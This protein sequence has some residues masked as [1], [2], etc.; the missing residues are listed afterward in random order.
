MDEPG[1]RFFRTIAQCRQSIDD[2][3]LKV[4]V[5]GRFS[6]GKSA[7]LNALLERELLA[8]DQGPETAVP[9][10]LV[11]DDNEYVELI[12]GPQGDARC[13]IAEIG[14]RDASSY[15][16]LR[17]HIR[18]DFLRKNK[19]YILV[20]MPGLDS[21]IAEHNKAI[22][23]YIGRGNAYILVVDCE[24]GEIKSSSIDF[25]REIKQYEHNLAIVVSKADK[26]PAGQVAEIVEQV[27][28]TAAA[29]FEKDIVAV[30]A[31]KFDNVV[32]QMEQVLSSF[33]IND[34]RAQVFAP[35][36]AELAHLELA[37]VK[38]FAQSRHFDDRELTE[39]ISMHQK[40]RER[41]VSL[42]EKERNKLA[43][44]IRQQVKPGIIADVQNVLYANSA[45]LASSLAAGGNAFTRTVNDLLRPVLIASTNRYTEASYQEFVRQINF[46]QVLDNDKL[47]AEIAAKYKAIMSSL[48]KM[49]AATDNAK[50]IY[51]S[52]TSILAI[53]TTVVAPWLEL[54]IVFLPDILKLF[55]GLVEK[56][57]ME[58]LRR[59]VET[60]IIPQIAAKLS[61]EMDESLRE[62]EANLIEEL[63]AKMN[64]LIEAE[65]DSLMAAQRLKQQQ[66]AAYAEAQ[67]E[68]S[69]DIHRLESLLQTLQPAMT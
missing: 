2:F 68:T 62:L 66:E 50:G 28:Q 67:R 26:K 8:E 24:D 65:T 10:E 56:S 37:A 22:M 15:Q 5:V 53:T 32:P 47:A 51:R 45:A 13:P 41:L 69:E 31:S 17:Y 46:G 61:L 27:R 34:I 44:K 63:E 1:I 30:S 36:I 14:Q 11:Y 12:G 54:I 64:D 3:S 57:R 43:Q 52:I 49:L 59:Q 25:L 39:K 23:Q 40:A 42:L 48:Q 18:H 55:G 35:Q 4:P 16:Y 7:L 29:I 9:C 6:A 58:Q 33:Q 60:E 38:Q 21:G 19:D 20:D